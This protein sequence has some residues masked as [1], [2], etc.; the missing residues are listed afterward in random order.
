MDTYFVILKFHLQAGFEDAGSQIVQIER[1]TKFYL[2]FS[3]IITIFALKIGYYETYR[4][5]IHID[6]RVILLMWQ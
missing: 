2:I 6:S 5:I 1:K 3:V 4:L